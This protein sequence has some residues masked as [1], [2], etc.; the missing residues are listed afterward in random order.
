MSVL[1]FLLDAGKHVYL[2]SNA[3]GKDRDEYVNKC[4]RLGF[5]HERLTIQN[6]YGSAYI[7]ALYVKNTF[8]DCK[9]CYI[10]G[11]NSIRNELKSFGITALGCED[12]HD[13]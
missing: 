7:A 5:V 8:P 12:D 2:I 11:M 10:I 4:K 6:V 1:K 3:S 13:S 9:K